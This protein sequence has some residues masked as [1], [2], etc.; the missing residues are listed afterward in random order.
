MSSSEWTNSLINWFEANCRTL[1]WRDEPTPYRVL[2]SEFM[3]Q[4][5]QVA[6]VVPY[7]NRFM[8]KYPT[9]DDLAAADMD[10]VVKLW[11]GLGYYSRARH[12]YQCAQEIKRL[13]CFPENPA[14]LVKLPGIGNYTAAAISSIAFGGHYPVVDG[15]VLRIRSRMAAD[16]T[17]IDS[18]A[19]KHRHYQELLG[20]MADIGNPSYFN[21]AMMELGALICHPNKPDCGHCPVKAFCKAFASGSPQD[22]PKK[23]KKAPVPHYHVAVA[24]IY[25]GE[26]FLILKRGEDQML[27]GLWE[28]P[29][30]KLETG[31]T[32]E[33]AVVREVREE[34]GLEITLGKEIAVVR[35]SYS[36]FK[37]TMHAFSCV[38]SGDSRKINT[39]RP[40]CWISL[41]E[42]QNYAFP[43]AN[44]KIF[45]ALQANA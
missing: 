39:D 42:I 5:T 27:G 17:L 4:Q 41:S 37:I 40:H 6:T 3:L 23:R 26:R 29:G 16:E 18:D 13:G 19:A 45:E 12:L 10:S 1:P 34:T 8:E 38:I 14:E 9:I 7:F 11:E 36:H 2:V 24:V 22:F 20:L 15:N 32:S 25:D 21:Q 35:H 44:H 30:G 33:E 43:K 31:E 28:F